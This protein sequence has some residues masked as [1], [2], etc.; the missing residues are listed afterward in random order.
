M[1]N[2]AILTDSSTYLPDQLIN[3]YSIRVVPHT[4]LWG[5]ETF[6]DGKD[7]QVCEIK[8]RKISCKYSQDTIRTILK[9][10][11]LMPWSN[12]G[13]RFKIEKYT[14][15]KTDA[16]LSQG[17]KALCQFLHDDSRSPHPICTSGINF[18]SVGPSCAF[19][20]VCPLADLGDVPLCPNAEV[21]TYLSEAS[22]GTR[23][24]RA[25]FACWA[26]PP[27]EHCQHCPDTLIAEDPKSI[28]FPIPIE[29]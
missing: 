19:C 21:Y 12:Y 1:V 26:D 4:F 2:V 29:P 27:E 8:S 22:T 10:H 23:V 5:S 13:G 3:K 20:R 11:K 25:E 24:I 16:E 9:T 18:A 15:A 28:M 7:I 6:L 17:M 14:T